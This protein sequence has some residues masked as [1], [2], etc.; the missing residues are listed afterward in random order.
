[1]WFH[2]YAPNEMLVGLHGATGQPA[3]LRYIFP[4]YEVPTSQLS[5]VRYDYAS[6]IKVDKAIDHVSCH[7]DGRFHIKTRD[8]QDLYIQ[9]MRRTQPLGPDT[10][11]FLEFIVCSHLASSYRPIEGKPKKPFAFVGLHDDQIVCLRSMFS[12]ARYPLE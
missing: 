3:T 4:E 2:N 1:M 5:A 9:S 7:I 10:S 8:D 6:A 11:T 12:G